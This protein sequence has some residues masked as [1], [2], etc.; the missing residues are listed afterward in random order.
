[1]QKV[2]LNIEK[3][4]RSI[5]ARLMVYDIVFITDNK[6]VVPTVVAITSLIAN[7]EKSHFY[8]VHIIT[9]N[10]T[11]YNRH[12]LKR[13]NTE[14]VD[15]D[16]I[17][18]SDLVC[19]YAH[20]DQNRH[21]TPSALLKFFL[22][23][24]F[25]NLN[26]ILYLDSDIILQKGFE[27]IFNTELGNS[28][29]AVVKDILCKL[30]RKH[31]IKFNIN[32][33]FYFN[34]GVLLLNLKKMREENIAQKLIDYRINNKNYFMDQ[35]TF[36]AVIGSN[37]KYISYKYNFLNYYLEKLSPKELSIFYDE[38]MPKYPILIYKNCSIVHL[39][40]VY[41]PWIYKMGY[42]SRLYKRYWK[43]SL[44]KNKKFKLIYLPDKE[45][46]IRHIFSIRNDDRQSHK[47]ITI[48]GLKFKF[49]RRRSN[50]KG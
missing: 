44:L 14:T 16:I 34:T 43:K 11:F 6:Y 37:V 35:D 47:V 7:K 5:G 46:Y 24:I 3:D 42:L 49:K 41:K 50:A 40:G 33:D 22:P 38:Y 45:P 13:L 39:G 4:H 48:L 18:K 26:K 25:P 27:D 31:M 17:D 29:A 8:N 2:G 19:Q 12:L 20:I 36:N 15:I 23:D 10:L 21:V 30:N 1:M 28:Y 32:N 9:T